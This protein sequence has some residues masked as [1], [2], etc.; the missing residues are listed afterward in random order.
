MGECNYYVR[1][2]CGALAVGWVS[3]ED[4]EWGEEDDPDDEERDEGFFDA[5]EV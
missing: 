2:P 5:I 3:E 1:E 4:F